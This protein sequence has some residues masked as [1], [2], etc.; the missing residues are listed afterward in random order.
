MSGRIFNNDKDEDD[1]L[2]SPDSAIFNDVDS[3]N[4]D[5]LF[6]DL[7]ESLKMFKKFTKYN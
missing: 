1:L 6:D 7:T 2:F 3:D 4:V 5:G